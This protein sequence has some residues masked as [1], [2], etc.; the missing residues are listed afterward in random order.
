MAIIEKRG[1]TYRVTVSCGYD[2]RGKQIKKKTTFVPPK[3]YT[4]KQKAAALDAFAQK[5]EAEVKGGYLAESYKIS[6]AEFIP[7]Y[8]E[9]YGEKLAPLTRK[10][11]HRV[12]DNIILPF[13]GHMKLKDI[14]SIHIQHFLVELQRPDQNGKRLSASS[15]QRYFVVLKS[16]MSQ[17]YKMEYINDNPTETA[18]LNVP[19][20]EQP[21][22]DIFSEEEAEYML[23]A[24]YDEPL[25]YQVLI[26]LAIITGAR[27]GELVALQWKHIDFDNL[28]VTIEQSNYREDGEIKT[29]K[30]K[31]K[32]S[33]RTIAIPDYCAELLMEYKKEQR[34]ERMKSLEIWEEGDWIFTQWNGKPM[35]PDTPSHWFN[36]FQERKGIP[37][38]KFHALRHTSATLT[39]AAGTDIRTVANRLGH[40]QLGTTYK[41]THILESA[42]KHAANLFQDM[43][44][45]NQN[46]T[47]MKIS[48]K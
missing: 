45:K 24:L 7:E 18:K 8:F 1:D 5:F 14:R 28:T 3:K 41:Y 2:S 46:R 48:P 25:M 12:I 20:V 47:R 39:L 35:S 17:A 34:R 33:I 13:L 4:E 43:Y 44:E 6:L 16:I 37:H 31:T 9:I 29:K 22:T 30:P 10:M 36:K 15:V 42:D 19:T 27:R 26:H 38:H 23:D 21:E 11:Y 32:G 40:T